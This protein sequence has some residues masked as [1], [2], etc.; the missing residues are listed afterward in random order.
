MGGIN[1]EV[2]AA[3]AEA[4]QVLAEVTGMASDSDGNAL[5]NGE[6]YVG[7]FGPSQVDRSMMFAGGYK[8]RSTASFTVTRGRM[9]EPPT[10]NESLTR[11]DT[12][13]NLVYRVEKVLTHDPI[14][15][16]V[17]LIAVNGANP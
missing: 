1:S 16:V 9:S 3:F 4:G 7:V 6:S 8:Q 5:Y 15:W 11:L 12:E 2:S 14:H 13:P 10:A 17:N